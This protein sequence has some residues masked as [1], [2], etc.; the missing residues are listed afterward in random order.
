MPIREYGFAPVGANARERRLST[1]ALALVWFGASVSLAEILTGTFFAPLGLNG[2]IAAILVGHAIGFVLFVLMA[3]AS[4]R[5]SLGAMDAVKLTFGRLGS[6]VFSVANVV[7]LVGWTA[8]MVSSG[9]AAAVYLVPTL[10]MGGWCAVI[11]A[12]I[13]VWIA[14]GMRHMSRVQ[15]VASVAL[16]AL[17]MVV[18]TVVFGAG[19]SP[20]PSMEPLPFGSAVELAVAMPLSWLPVVGDYT[21]EAK[22]PLAG[23]IAAATTYS[24]G[25]CWMFAIGLGLALFAGSGD[26]AEVLSAAGLGTVGILV[27]VFSTVTT[28]FLDAQSAGISAAAIHARIPAKWTGVAV[29]VVGAVAAAVAPVANF[30]E[31]LYL[32]GSVFAPMAAVFIVDYLVC[33]NDASSKPFNLVNL[34]I[35]LGGF[36]LYRVT[37]N[38]DFILGNTLPVMVVTAAAT[39]VVSR[40]RKKAQKA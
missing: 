32:I 20:S 15:A 39:L 16:F 35:W 1:P 28:T 7:Q 23:S 34:A 27:V 10:G 2:G 5:S 24:L 36:V 12:L 29:A 30:E 9:A 37:M 21:R 4:A 11:G 22:R 38:A 13:V 17:T 19:G 33:G 8:I 18:S 31:F 25:S 6:L 14:V 3:Y 26:L 40:I